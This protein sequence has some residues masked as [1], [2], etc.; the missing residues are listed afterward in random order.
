M[1]NMFIPGASADDKNEKS[2]KGNKNPT[3]TAQNHNQVCYKIMAKTVV[4]F[5][6]QLIRLSEGVTCE[7]RNYFP[8]IET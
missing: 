2:L 6:C 8:N 4:D 7:I 5:N 1:S 3:S